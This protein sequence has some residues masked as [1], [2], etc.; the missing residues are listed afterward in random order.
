MVSGVDMGA[1]P[2]RPEN[3]RNLGLTILARLARFSLLQVRIP[4]L[5][6]SW[7]AT[8]ILVSFLLAV[9]DDPLGLFGV[10]RLSVP[11]II[12]AV[13][14]SEA[15]LAVQVAVDIVPAPQLLQKLKVIS[16]ILD[17]LF[18]HQSNSFLHESKSIV[19]GSAKRRGLGCV[20]SLPGS[21]W[22]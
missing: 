17:Q 22:L 4:P 8:L 14:Q 6:G 2:A 12:D 9:F 5:S 10:K 7:V 3:T 18:L 20:N 1:D 19:Q 16:S 21:A 13:V 15:Q 11:D